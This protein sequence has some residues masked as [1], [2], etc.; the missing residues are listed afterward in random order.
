MGAACLG[1]FS[2]TG[3]GLL[4]I[5]MLRREKA[6]R[7]AEHERLTSALGTQEAG[8]QSRAACSRRIFGG[9]RQF[10]DAT[11]R[12][13]ES[14]SC[15]ASDAAF[16]ILSRVKDLDQSASQLV[17]Y[18]DDADF[19]AVDL[20][21]EIDGSESQ[22]EM[23][24]NYLRDLPSQMAQQK[25]A[26]EALMG[27]VEQL[28]A[29]AAQIKEISDRTGL[30][31]LNASI[32]AARAGEAGRG[33]SIVAQEVRNLAARSNEVAS[34]IALRVGGFNQTLNANFV[35][36][37]TDGIEE[38]MEAAANLPEFI[39]MVHKNYADIRQ[40]YKTMLT[41]VT[42]HNHE[43]AGGLS[44]ML[45]NVQFQ[46]VVVQQVDRLRTMMGD[47][48]AVA[49]MLEQNEMTGA[50]LEMA[51]SRISDVVDNFEQLDANHHAIADGQSEADNNRIELF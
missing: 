36:S 17:S 18:L 34:D 48:R 46:D 13:F 4:M 50:I 23:V 21:Q 15:Q 45:G 30:L 10:V 24:A 44:E 19:D 31:S 42:E 22:L 25:A 8:E 43:I 12:P 7:L 20:K 38:K 14:I 39:Q 32:E 49:Q 47:M 26:M 35:W 29:A 16:S 28:K 33:F 9:W 41:V 37:L 5:W 27:E 2:V 6:L 3:I 51:E 40:Y 11:E 1:F